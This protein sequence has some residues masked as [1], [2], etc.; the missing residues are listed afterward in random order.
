M[1]EWIL[2]IRGAVD[3][4]FFSFF[5]RQ[6]SNGFKRRFLFW[7]VLGRELL[8]T[9]FYVGKKDGS[10]CRYQLMDSWAQM[11]SPGELASVAG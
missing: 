1:P 4:F 11:G 9:E 5:V 10:E 2:A 7:C 6:E 8:S 3:T